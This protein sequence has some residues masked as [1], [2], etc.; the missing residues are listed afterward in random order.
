M[1]RI[2]NILFPNITEELEK[3]KSKNQKCGKVDFK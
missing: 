2:Q 1:I 3:S